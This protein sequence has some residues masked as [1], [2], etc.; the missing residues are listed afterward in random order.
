MKE[1]K[2]VHLKA[3]ARYIGVYGQNFEEGATVC[4]SHEE[5][6]YYALCYGEYHRLCRSVA[7]ELLGITRRRFP[8]RRTK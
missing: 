4:Y 2:R 8:S 1:V 3:V 7:K 5:D 6:Q